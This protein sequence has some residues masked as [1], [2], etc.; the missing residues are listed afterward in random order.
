MKLHPALAYTGGRF[1]LIAAT[2]AVLYLLGFRTWPLA[3]GAIA[4]SLPLSYFVLRRQREGFAAFLVERHEKRT[5]QKEKL[6]SALRGS[7]DATEET[8]EPASK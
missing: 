8:Q 4:I 6:R 2:A 5:A 7:E 3:F 1:V